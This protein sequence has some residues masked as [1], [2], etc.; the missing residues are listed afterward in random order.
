MAGREW[1]RGAKEDAYR[2][3]GGKDPPVARAAKGLILPKGQID[4]S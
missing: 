4:L 1:V 2:Q 3:I